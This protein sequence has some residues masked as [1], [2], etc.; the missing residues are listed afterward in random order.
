MAQVEEASPEGLPDWIRDPVGVARRRWR[1]ALVGLLAGLVLTAGAA[2]LRKPVYLAKASVLLADQQ[3]ADSLVKPTSQ[4]SPVDAMDAFTAEALSVANL[5]KLIEELGLYAD[6]RDERSPDELVAMLR[7]ATKVDQPMTPGVPRPPPGMRMGDRSRVMQIGFESE[8]AVEA[9]KVAN[10]L[11]RLFETEAARMRREKARHATEF[12]RRETAAAE[13]ALREK[14][15]EIAAYE[16]PHRG[17]LPSDIE[18]NNRRV[19]RLQTQREQLVSSA[20]EAETR[21]A[22]VVATPSSGEG[23]AAAQLAE[24]RAALATARSV[25]TETHP[26]VIAL[27]RR[28]AQLERETGGGGG[29]AVAAAARREVAQYREQIAATD[30]EL[31]ALDARIARTPSHE[32]EL[33]A[34]QQR[35]KALEDTYLEVLGKLTEAELA[36]SLENAQQGARV[37]VI[38]EAVPPLRP[39]KGRLKIVL[40]GLVGSLGLAGA[41][42][43]LLELRD[44]VIATAKGVEAL[45]GVPVLGVMPRVS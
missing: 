43:L 18:N 14:K 11:A 17:E 31:D 44:P 41:L 26:N 9:A 32:A 35:A 4:A 3:L 28:V 30:A 16:E 40:A 21:L 24:A 7:G 27:K 12:M 39:E 5:K 23:T 33:A 15:N 20:A 2:W 13:A 38:E 25:N 45:S 42:A 37:A 22:Q 29:G 19:D 10:A 36:E 1:G 8:D 34:L 6:L